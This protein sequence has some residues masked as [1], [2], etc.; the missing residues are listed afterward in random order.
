MIKKKEAGKYGNQS[1]GLA[2]WHIYGMK[3]HCM[4]THGKMYDCNTFTHDQSMAMASCRNLGWRK[5]PVC[6]MDAQLREFTR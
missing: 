5:L 6:A 3:N 2:Q 4:I 1:P